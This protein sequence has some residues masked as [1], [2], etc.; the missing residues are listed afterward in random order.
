MGQI[1]KGIEGSTITNTLN[2]YF[3]LDN[4]LKANDK[5]VDMIDK[6]A[7]SG[8]FRKNPKLKA[9]SSDGQKFH[10]AVPS[11]QA[12]Y[13]IKY[14]GTGKGVSVYSFINDKYALFFN[15]VITSS[16]REAPYVIDGILHNDIDR[17]DGE[18]QGNKKDV[19]DID[20][21]HS[22]DTH[23]FTEIV[24]GVTHL[25]NITFAP[26]LKEYF[27]QT[28]YGFETPAT[29][30]EKGYFWLPKR[31][32]N[33][34]LII[35]QWD[36]I[37]RLMTTIRLKEVPASVIL[38]RLSSYAKQNPLYKALKEFGRII[39]TIFLLRYI[40][41]VN[42]RQQI[43]YQLNLVELSHQFAKAVFFGRSGVFY[44]ASE[45]QQK[46]VAA[47]RMLVQ[48]AI[49]LWNYLFLSKKI[50]KCE[51]TEEIE[52]IFKIIREGA[53][54]TWQ[55]VHLQGTYNFKEN[56]VSNFPASEMTKIL[57]MDLDDFINTAA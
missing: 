49:I 2:W 5:I 7:L 56:F 14:Y 13:S 54:I 35:Q 37:L 52:K 30:K 23:G 43:Q 10:I 31:T 19:E 9:T 33:T 42:L 1:A 6:M 26:R 4:I 28:I 8:I 50:L 17:I 16:E 11:L 24:F 41:D 38:K 18:N 39:K 36:N 51:T 44:E 57:D 40:D 27:K 47:C 55:H 29:Y 22:T 34:G 3:S 53:M 48:N 25:L 20:W 46:I 21:Q 45:E 15:T 12:T 32:V